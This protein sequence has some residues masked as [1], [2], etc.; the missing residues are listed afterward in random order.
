LIITQ[1]IRN[2]CECYLPI[3]AVTAAFYRLYRAALTYPPILSSTPFH[4]TM[5]WADVF[6]SLPLNIQLS[7][8]PAKLLEALLADRTLLTDFLCTSFM[9]SRFYNGFGRYPRQQE[10][11]RSWLMAGNMKTV[12]CLDAACGT[13]EGGYEIAHVL[14]EAGF[15]PEDVYI[16]GWTLEPL[17]V[18]A[19][20]TRR[21]PNDPG[22]EVDFQKM[23]SSLLEPE[24]QDT[25]HFRCADLLLLSNEG[26]YDLIICNGL[27]GGPIINS[28]DAIDRVVMHLAQLL[29]S[30]GLLLAADRFH[31][32]WKQHCPQRELQAVFERYGLES[33]ITDDGIAGHKL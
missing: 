2:Q 12:R 28:S 33:L 19:A 17:E 9:P 4:K 8:N 23:V 14:S 21:F 3:A 24:F 7:A 5:S 31:G 22:R 11:V 10:F 30:K 16:D 29:A 15:S 1:E 20:T 32:G 25:I 6:A 26:P 27:L 18:W 13:G